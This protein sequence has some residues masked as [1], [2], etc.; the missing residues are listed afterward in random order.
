QCEGCGYAIAQIPRSTNCPECGKPVADSLPERRQPPLFATAVGRWSKMRSFGIT[1]WAALFDKTF[2]QRLSVH[3]HSAAARSYFLW[4]GALIALFVMTPLVD[5][6]PSATS[7]TGSVELLGFVLA[8]TILMFIAE[9]ILCGLLIVFD[10]VV[11]RR[12]V[13]VAANIV[14]YGLS[15]LLPVA[16]ALAFFVSAESRLRIKLPGIGMDN[17]RTG[18][19]IA[20]SAV[21]FVI[22]AACCLV[23]WCSF[24]RAIRDTKAANA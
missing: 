16:M 23:A 15:A 12:P 4:L 18:M 3:P 2:F 22:G 6:R 13:Q 8:S 14:F 20:I 19:S 17:P 24:R 11:R 10:A 9:F 5:S 1:L 7:R 21:L